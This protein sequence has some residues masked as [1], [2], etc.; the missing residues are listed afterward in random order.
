M[1]RSSSLPL[2]YLQPPWGT[3]GEPLPVGIIHFFFDTRIPMVE[4]FRYQTVKK[5]SAWISAVGFFFDQ[6]NTIDRLFFI[7]YFIIYLFYLGPVNYRGLNYRG[8]NY[9]GLNYRGLKFIF[10]LFI[11]YLFL[12]LILF[13]EIIIFFHLLL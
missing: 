4:F 2:S 1:C 5:A 12:K 6:W 3:A 7:F 8:L 9:R 10:Y 13:N 11:F